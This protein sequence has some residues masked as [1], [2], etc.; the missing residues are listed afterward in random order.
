MLMWPVQ[1]LIVT[2]DSR[3]QTFNCE[4]FAVTVQQKGR[5]CSASLQHLDLVSNHVVLFL[6]GVLR[7]RISDAIVT[8]LHVTHILV[9]TG[10]ASGCFPQLDSLASMTHATL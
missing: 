4:R 1:Y 8:C 9:V 10:V 2:S 3:Q 6:R 5:C 7:R